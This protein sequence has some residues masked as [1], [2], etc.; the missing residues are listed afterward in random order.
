MLE[1]C[2]CNLNPIDQKKVQARVFTI[3][4][5][6]INPS[7]VTSK[8]HIFGILTLVLFYS[9]ATHSFV[10]AKFMGRLGRI[11]ATQDISYNVTILSKDVQQTNVILKVCMILLEN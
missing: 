7:V 9:E 6:E 4:N 8:F 10:S 2:P 3:T 5:A 1:H 11:P